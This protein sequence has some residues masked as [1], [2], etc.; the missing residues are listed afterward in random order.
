M[1]A[2]NKFGYGKVE[3]FITQSPDRQPVEN[4]AL[5]RTGIAPLA[6]L[7]YEQQ[8]VFKQKQVEHVMAKIAKMPEVPV[9]PTVG[10]AEPFGYRNKAQIPVRRIDGQLAT[11]FYKRI[12]MI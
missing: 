12:A 7:K 8:L 2:G 11:G 5:L 3:T 9:L 10:M 4:N 1:K 6:H